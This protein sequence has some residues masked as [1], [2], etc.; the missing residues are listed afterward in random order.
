CYRFNR[1]YDLEALVI[2]LVV[3]AARTPPLTYRL[4]TV[5]A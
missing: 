1:R 5:D 4:A 3:A 2:R